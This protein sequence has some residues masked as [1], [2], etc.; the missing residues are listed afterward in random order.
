[1]TTVGGEL[2]E[3]AETMARAMC[4]ADGHDPDQT[5]RASGAALASLG[6]DPASAEPLPRWRLYEP[7][8]R[9]LIEVQEVLLKEQ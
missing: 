4:R 3:Q 7:K 6:G 2:L 8:A 9:Q 1:M 5:I